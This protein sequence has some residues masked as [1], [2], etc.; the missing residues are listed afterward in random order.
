MRKIIVFILYLFSTSMLLAWTPWPLPMDSVDSGCD[1]LR[2][3]TNYSLLVST[4]KFAPFWMSTNT[5]GVVSISP[6]ATHL[7]AFVEKKDT[8]SAR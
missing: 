3:S 6:I 8:R 4:G 2:Y 5:D 1:V 7:R